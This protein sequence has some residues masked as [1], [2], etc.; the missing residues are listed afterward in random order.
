[1][2]KLSLL[3]FL[4]FLSCSNT[5]QLKSDCNKG[6]GEACNQLGKT[7]PSPEDIALFRK[8]CNL[9]NTNGCVNLSEKVDHQEAIRVLKF[10]CDKGNT[11]ACA[12]LAEKSLLKQGK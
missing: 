8:A 2:Q 3:F 1:M 10:S 11:R 6:N 7:L 9:G 5:E 12:K 4:F